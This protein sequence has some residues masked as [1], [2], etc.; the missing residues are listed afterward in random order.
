MQLLKSCNRALNGNKARIWIES[1]ITT[2]PQ[3]GGLR[4]AGK[5]LLNAFSSG[6]CY[7]L[8]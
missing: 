1:G 4:D 6:R 7:D 2:L 5:I 3:T 8:Q